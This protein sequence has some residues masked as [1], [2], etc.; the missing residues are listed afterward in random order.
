M[1][2]Y[3]PDELERFYQ[4]DST[5]YKKLDVKRG[6][7]NVDGSGVLAGLT[8]ISSVKGFDKTANGITP[9]E[10]ELRYRGHLV[11]DLIDQFKGSACVFE[12]VAALLL[13]GTILDT[14]RLETFKLM[15]A[16]KRQVTELMLEHQIKAVPHHNVMNKCQA[17][18]ASLG[19]DDKD[20]DEI[21]LEENIAKA[22]RII[23]VFPNLV[24]YTYLAN[25]KENPHFVEAKADQKLAHA[26]LYVLREGGEVS[27]V[28]R[29]TLDLCLA[30][31]AEHGGGNNSSFTTHVVSS[32]GANMYAALSAAMGSLSGPLHGGAN[33]KVMEMM[34][35]IKV[36]VSNWQDKEEIKQVLKAILQKKVGDGSGKIYGL[37]HAVYTKSDPRAVILKDQ[38]KA[39]AKEKGREAEYALYETI[40]V[41]GP[42]VFYEFKGDS[43]A[44][45]ANV[46][47]YSG[48]VYDCLNIPK[49]VYTPM[50]AMARMVGWASHMCEEFVSGRRVIRPGY[51]FVD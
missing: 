4:I 11:D 34:D 49:E 13:T 7:R 19:Q 43:K 39:L 17:L 12:Q 16:Q 2:F 45:C 36:S 20:L 51:K 22:M 48:F 14:D 35:V 15:L 8:K 9:V 5:L 29:H 50:F 18:I 31:H 10:G 6:L 30:L 33:Q 47:F 28:E 3:N 40:E 25:F 32:T 27:E 26:F 21:T 44:I 24:A 46:D 37:G 42:E 41:L 1:S 38:A 23:A